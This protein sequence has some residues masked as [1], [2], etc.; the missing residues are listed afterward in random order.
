MGKVEWSE[1][2]LLGMW[3]LNDSETFNQYYIWIIL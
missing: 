1:K 3:F 2:T